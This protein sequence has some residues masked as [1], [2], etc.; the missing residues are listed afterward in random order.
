MDMNTKNKRAMLLPILLL[1]GT[2]LTM[3]YCVMFFSAST[4]IG[5]LVAFCATWAVLGIKRIRKKSKFL[6]G[7][8]MKELKK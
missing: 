3:A 6:Q 8:E 1:L 5:I 2:I 4:T 7:K